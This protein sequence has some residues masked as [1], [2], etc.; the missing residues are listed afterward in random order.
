MNIKTKLYITKKISHKYP[1]KMLPFVKIF[2]PDQYKT[3]KMCDNTYPSNIQFALDCYK[4][5]EMCH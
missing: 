5:Q 1:V 3:H 4:T 2:V